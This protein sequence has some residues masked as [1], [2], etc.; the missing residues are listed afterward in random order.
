MPWILINPKDLEKIPD[1]A[2]IDALFSQ[3]D[4]KIMPFKEALQFGN[5]HGLF[6][7]GVVYDPS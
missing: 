5:D 3:P 4:R 6:C 2:V 1:F 7:C